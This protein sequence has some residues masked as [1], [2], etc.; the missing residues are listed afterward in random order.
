MA[1]KPKISMAKLEAAREAVKRQYG[2][3]PNY[4]GADI[5][6]RWDKGK[7]TDELVVRVH[8]TR[9]IPVAEIESALV[10]PAT[11]EGVPLDVIEGHY[12]ASASTP[13]DH[14][15]PSSILMGGVSCGRLDGGTGTAG[16]IVID[17]ETSRPGILSNWHV[18]AGA[19]ARRGDSIVHPGNLDGPAGGNQTVAKLERMILN[20]NGDAAVAL[21]E[22]GHP[23]MPLQFGSFL[24]VT[25][26]R[27]SILGET[28]SKA[29]RT[30]GLTN[31]IVDGE[32]TYRVQYEVQPGIVE[33]R[34]IDGFKLVST[35][36][37]AA[38]DEEISAA[39]DSGS[40]WV[41]E[42]SNAAVGLHFAGEPSGIP[43]FEFSIACNIDTVL[44]HLKVR[45]ATFEDWISSGQNIAQVQTGNVA[46][47]LTPNPIDPDWP[48]WPRWPWW[49]YPNPNPWPPGGGPY[50]PFPYPPGPFPPM[51]FP[52]GPFPPRPW[53]TN[54]HIDLNRNASNSRRSG[55]AGPIMAQRGTAVAQRVSAADIWAE[56]KVALRNANFDWPNMRIGDPVDNLIIGPG[57]P[58]YT[59][60]RIINGHPPFLYMGLPPIN[61]SELLPYPQFTSICTYL[62]RLIED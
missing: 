62:S 45:L 1:R 20:S 9:K 38:A 16:L 49:P 17:E 51:P 28:L 36:T 26:H 59:L 42:G 25:S 55:L 50:P 39:G 15:Q 24:S 21:L 32:G 53:R 3:R 27:R 52:P 47:E 2:H 12:H 29:G 13:N 54:D 43:N 22:P 5:G 40:A 30:T 48:D 44:D 35:P 7:R 33:G 31:G 60:A 19:H 10:F 23:W 18:L 8:V 46:P 41:H 14:Q 4:T 6:Y 11:I 34:D 61:G 57:D 37:G 58:H 56:L